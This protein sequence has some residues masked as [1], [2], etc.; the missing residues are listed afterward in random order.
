LTCS[1]R[2]ASASADVRIKTTA[3]EITAAATVHALVA[4]DP[5]MG[6]MTKL[7]VCKRSESC[8]EVSIGGAFSVTGSA[9]IVDATASSASTCWPGS[10][11]RQPTR[12]PPF[13]RI[14]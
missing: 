4:Q 2:V 11:R 12:Y 3:V 5:F 13:E 8:S 7:T 9:Y 1:A 6:T 10:A 14:R